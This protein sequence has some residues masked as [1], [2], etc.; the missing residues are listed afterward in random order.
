LANDSAAATRTVPT[1]LI[2][3]MAGAGKTTIPASGPAVNPAAP[4]VRSAPPTQSI[5]ERDGAGRTMHPV[6][7][8]TLR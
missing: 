4:H 2:T 3:A 7:G 8:A 5:M 6:A 1:R